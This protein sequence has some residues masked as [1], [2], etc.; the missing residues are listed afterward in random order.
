LNNIRYNR[1]LLI[2]WAE[3]TENDN[4]DSG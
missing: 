4:S 1:E 2:A 3:Q